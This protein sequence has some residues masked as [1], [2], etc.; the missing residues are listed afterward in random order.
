MFF[1]QCGAVHL[2]DEM[3]AYTVLTHS[4]KIIA[5]MSFPVCNCNLA[6]TRILKL[7]FVDIL[8]LISCNNDVNWCTLIY[9]SCFESV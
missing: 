5:N 8:L 4:V 3:T 2:S 9:N 6:D 7:I 1:K